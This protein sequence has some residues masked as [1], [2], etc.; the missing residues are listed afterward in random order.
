MA[1][2]SKWDHIWD[3]DS[4]TLTLFPPDI[5][6]NT[7]AEKEPPIFTCISDS[8]TIDE[9]YT[10]EQ[11]ARRIP[12]LKV[13]LAEDQK[14]FMYTEAR[15]TVAEHYRQFLKLIPALKLDRLPEIEVVF[16]AER[17]LDRSKL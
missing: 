5:A 11:L 1:D 13:N 7:P 10:R 8:I 12:A 2:L 3:P 16:P 4:F 9:E 17:G 15:N 14:Q 6:A